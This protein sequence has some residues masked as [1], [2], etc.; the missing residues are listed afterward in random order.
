MPLTSPPAT[1]PSD[2]YHYSV[3]IN[4]ANSLCYCDNCNGAFKHLGGPYGLKCTTL[5]RIENQWLC[6]ICADKI[7]K[8]E[9]N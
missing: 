9:D 8:E 5:Q 6:K 3:K 2:N 4:I 1:K 7:Q